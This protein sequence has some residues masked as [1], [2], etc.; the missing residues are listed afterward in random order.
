MTQK[1]HID[2]FFLVD[3]HGVSGGSENTAGGFGLLT[4]PLDILIASISCTPSK[5]EKERKGGN[6]KSNME[7]QKKQTKSFLL[8]IFTPLN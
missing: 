8:N 2:L 6:P 5:K 7:R 3:I 4:P 1:G